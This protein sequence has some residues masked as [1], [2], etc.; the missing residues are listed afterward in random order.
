MINS[1]IKEQIRQYLYEVKDISDINKKIIY[2]S[3]KFL[4]SK[5][6]VSPLIGDKDINESF[7]IRFD[8]FDCVTFVETIIT[9]S[10]AYNE[11]N[12]EKILKIIRYKENVISWNN[13]N[14]YTYEWLLNN[15]NLGYIKIVTF[16]EYEFQINKKLNILNGYREIDSQINYISL[17]LFNKMDMLLE[18][19]HIP[20]H[21][22]FGSFKENLDF[23]HVG[24]IVTEASNIVLY[25]SA[26]SLGGV[27][28]ENIYDFIKRNEINGFM[29]S[30]IIKSNG[31]SI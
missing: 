21:I 16:P 1:P 11:N 15:Q 3:N 27:V 20:H 9:L 10:L 30:K 25:H 12:F 24:I 22:A 7:V 14:H 18:F 19:F 13:R 5:Y 28:K 4:G 8:G 23:F 6:I 17:D 31:D 29:I 2:F 26:K